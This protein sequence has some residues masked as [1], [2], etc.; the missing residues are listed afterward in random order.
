MKKIIYKII[1]II[2]LFIVVCSYLFNFNKNDDLDNIKLSEVA[3][4]VFYT[5][6]YVAIHNGY[7]KDNGINVSLITTPGAD[8]VAASVLSGDSDIGFSGSEATIYIYNKNENDYLK[9][10]ARLTNKDGSFI[11]TRK[12]YKNFKLEDL[13]GLNI[14]GGR[15]N[16][17]PQM[18]LNYILKK[19][20]INANIDTS[21]NFDAM[22]S[23]FI[24]GLGDAVCLFEPTAT[25]V[26]S[27][28]FGYKAAAIG[29]YSGSV[30]YTSFYAK[31]SY[32]ND[33]KDLI[34]RFVKSIDEGLNHTLNTD[35]KTLANEIKDEFPSTSLE[36]LTKS[37]ESYKKIEAWPK[38][39]KFTKNDFDRMQDIMILNN[40]ISKKVN[41]NDLMYDIKN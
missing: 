12:K 3:H 1:F 25:E 24:G 20:N 36:S 39:S 32:I 38:N 11:V 33:N 35:S 2:I 29:A 17:M 15:L 19:N 5:P 10:F 31:K 30:P 22:A 21:V 37:I 34:G 18:T 28:G 41:F 14:I 16:G 27:K 8:K 9:S 40:A 23:S 6:M 13:N 4:S 26:V 7:F